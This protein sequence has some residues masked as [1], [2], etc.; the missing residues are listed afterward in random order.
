MILTAEKMVSGADC[1]A[2]PDGK[3]VFIPYAIPGERLEVA[4]TEERRDFCRARILRV[5]EASPYRVTPR[6]PHYMRCGGCSMQHI[7]GRYQRRLREQ[8]LREAFVRNGVAV[9]EITT[10]HAADY[11]YRSRFQLHDGGLL[12]ARSNTVVPIEDC[13]V[14]DEAVSGW[15]RNTPCH[16]RPRGRAHLFAG[17]ELVIAQE[18]A[19][20]ADGSTR[21]I[22][23]AKRAERLKARRNRHF[24]GTVQAPSAKCTVTLGGKRVAFD[25]RGFFQSNIPVLEQALPL[26]YGGI[27][28]RHVLDMYGGAGTFSVFLAECFDHVTLV[29]H[30]RDAIVYAEEN[31]AG[32]PHT[33]FG[34]SGERFVRTQVEPAQKDFGAFEAV[35]IDPPRSGMEKAVR[36]WLCTRPA[37]QIRSVSCDPATHARDAAALVSAGYTLTKLCL[38][39]FYPQTGHIESLAYFEDLT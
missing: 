36:D 24:P 27:G 37:F 2:R 35:V 23:G 11:G 29:E 32:F 33:C 4:I 10:V 8:V 30:N 31:L 28:G 25:V 18:E 16:A 13:P 3:T 14:A 26:L 9:P 6:C 20:R 21:V 19:S 5:L 39:D 7:D 15:L 1:M 22:G 12:A 38:L 17:D 34:M